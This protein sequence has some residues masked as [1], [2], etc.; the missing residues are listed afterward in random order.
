MP[1]DLDKAI[2]SLQNELLNLDVRQVEI[3]KAINQ[4]MAL[5][6][7]PPKYTDIEQPAD[8]IGRY[9]PQ[10]RE[11]VGKTLLDSV[12]EYLRK[13]GRASTAQEILD[14]LTSGDYQFS[15]T[16]KSKLKLKNL[17][18]FLG[19]NKE[20]VQ[21]DTQDG[22]A[23]G[24]AERYPDKVREREKNIEKRDESKNDGVI[25]VKLEGKL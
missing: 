19:S 24:L 25:E 23:Y 2:E 3:K 6:G 1:N 18:I 20:F 8:R 16:W 11:F 14:G 15:A 4:L 21:F 9:V 17:A 7:L 12:K 5:N 10:S 22:K 13:T